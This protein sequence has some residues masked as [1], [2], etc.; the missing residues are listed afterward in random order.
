MNYSVTVSV[1][2]GQPALKLNGV[3]AVRM[4]VIR[5]L[6]Q[7]AIHQLAENALQ[8][9]EVKFEEQKPNDSN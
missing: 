1:E 3:G 8:T 7:W 9:A 5:D 2:N 6:L 4:A